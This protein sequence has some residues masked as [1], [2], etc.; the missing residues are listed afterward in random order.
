MYKLSKYNIIEEQEIVY[1]YNLLSR[2]FLALPNEK[3]NIIKDNNFGEL[4]KDEIDL[5]INNNIII[6]QNIDE[7]EL[8]L[9]NYREVFYSNKTV[10]IFFINDAIL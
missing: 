4:L 6:P 1:V 7:E 9:D 3:W 2:V 8:L 5:L 10:S